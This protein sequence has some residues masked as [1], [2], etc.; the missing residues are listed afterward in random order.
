MKEKEMIERLEA[1]EAENMLLAE[2]IQTLYGVFFKFT[3]Q[4]ANDLVL[5]RENSKDVYTN[6]ALAT[7]VDTLHRAFEKKGQ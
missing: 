6:K 3:E 7:V 2:K 1:L 4:A 5:L